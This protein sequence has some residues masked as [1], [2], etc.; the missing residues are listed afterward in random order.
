MVVPFPRPSTAVD[1]TMY[2]VL[3]HVKDVNTFW[4]CEMTDSIQNCAKMP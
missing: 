2:G 1:A 4:R 3:S